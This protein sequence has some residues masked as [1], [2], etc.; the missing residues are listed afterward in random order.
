[1]TTFLFLRGWLL[2]EEI[3]ATTSCTKCRVWGCWVMAVNC[4][5]S[6]MD[7]SFLALSAQLFCRYD[8]PVGRR[9]NRLKVVSLHTLRNKILTLQHHS[10]IALKCVSSWD[11]VTILPFLCFASRS[12]LPGSLRIRQIHLGN[13]TILENGKTFLASTIYRNI[14]FSMIRI[15]D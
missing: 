5:G 1:M 8:R 10:V 13:P 3:L 2:H 15:T 12:S 4:V 6:V 9:P 11:L 14:W 7:G